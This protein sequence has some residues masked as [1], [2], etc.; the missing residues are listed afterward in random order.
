MSRALPERQQEIEAL[1]RDLMK[2]RGRLEDLSAWA[3]NTRARLE[4]SPE[5]PPPRVG[6]SI[7]FL[8]D[9]TVCF[10][11]TTLCLLQ[12]VMEEVQVKQPEVDSVLERADR[13]LK[14]VPD[15]QTEK[16]RRSEKIRR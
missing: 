3:V 10:A 6:H 1:L 16:V 15:T 2:L 5:E 12:Q 8:K 13:V 4:Q 14:E 11:V 7:H 9:S